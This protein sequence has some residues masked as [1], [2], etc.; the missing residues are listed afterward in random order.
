MRDENRQELGGGES[1]DW[2]I[3]LK[4]WFPT[5][6]DSKGVRPYVEA[7]RALL[8]DRHRAGAS[9]AEIVHAYSAMIDQLL[10]HLYE[11]ARTDYHAHYPTMNARCAVVAQ[12]GYGRG[13][14]NPQSDIDL[15]FLYVWRVN[16]YVEYVTEKILYALWDGGFQV[17]H[18]T[19]TVSE[20]V[21]HGK[22]DSIVQTA[23]VDARFLCGDRRLFDDLAGAVRPRRG[24]VERFVERKLEERRLR[25]QRY[26]ESVF[27]LEPDLKEG[28]GGIRDIQSALW[29][30]RVKCDVRQLGDLQEKGLLDQGDVASLSR[31][32]DFLWRVRN[33]LHFASGKHQDQLTFEIQEQIAGDLG[34]SSEEKLSEVET[35]MR[36]YYLHA[37]E[38]SRVSSLAIH[39]AV[40]HDPHQRRLRHPGRQLRAGVEVKGSTLAVSPG[41]SFKDDPAQLLQLFVDLQHNKLE[42][43]QDSRGLIRGQ[44]EAMGSDL[45]ASNDAQGLFLDILRGKEWIYETLQELHR[46]NVLDALVPEFGRVRCMALHDLYH[47]Y[48]VD[49]HL[50]RAVKEFER[51][52]EG[53]F[54]ESLPL[55]SQLARETTKS[56]ILILGILFHDIGK[57]QGGGHSELGKRLAVDCAARLGLNEDETEQLSFLVLR[58]LLLPDVAFRR[59]IED[60]KVVLDLADA[61][62]SAENLRLLYL[63]TYSDMKAVS[64]DVWNSWKGSLLEDLYRS[65]HRVLEDREKGEFERPDRSL[66]LQRIQS[67]VLEKLAG[68]YQ[69][70]NAQ[71]LLE[72]MPD[73]YFLSTPEDDMPLHFSLLEQLGDKLFLTTVRHYPEYGHSEMVVCAKD[74][75]GL[76]AS[77]TGVFASIGLNILSA[78]I[79]TLHD[80][81]II[82]VFRISHQ[83]HP[84]V[85]MEPDKWSRVQLTLERVLRGDADVFD[86][87]RRSETGLISPRR[88]VSVPTQIQA[89]NG[90][91]EDFTVVEV[92]TQDRTGVLFRIAYCLHKLDFSIHL[93]KISTNV[94]QVADVFY[95]TEN[96]GTKVEN[97][98]RLEHVRDTLYGELSEADAGHVH[99]GR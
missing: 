93:A 64:P 59:D 94:D 21:R 76:F 63:L 90:A 8:Y 10:V 35:F 42:M 38:I 6:S 67:R 24:Q 85:V 55:L 13:E 41:I 4:A 48:T 34:F 78:R 2:G 40:D 73:R 3:L 60:E 7:G 92:Y 12:G 30:S 82:D 91:S 84:E 27:L 56:E 74:Q 96:D 26:G 89:D 23:M 95:V 80:G 29:I 61:M 71:A 1:F 31:G 20:C 66:K 62:G 70:D 86:L 46:T 72:L 77:I 33:E 44:V 15:L 65:T 68:A 17:G 57:G 28:Q 97:K 52:R 43:G 22:Q 5:S 51:L 37:S 14:L 69:T 50:M 45:V 25:H 98:G 79:H 39:R 18:A 16:P 32:Q 9:G 83:G 53:E 19:R 54:K 49:Q 36:A 88:R 11:S 58:H 47:I 87:V 81:R 75:P 99:N